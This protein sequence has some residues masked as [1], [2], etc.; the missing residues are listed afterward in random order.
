MRPQPT[1]LFGS[2]SCN[3]SSSTHNETFS[4]INSND[5]HG[6]H[7]MATFHDNPIPECLHSGFIGAK[8]DGGGGDNWSYMACKPTVKSSPSVNQHPTF[9]RPD[10][11]LVAEAISSNREI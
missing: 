11:L 7:L 5:T 10:A 2:G 3:S 4:N 8:D 1:C 9:Y 6:T